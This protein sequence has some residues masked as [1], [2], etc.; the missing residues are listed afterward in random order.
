M[1]SQWERKDPT[2]DIQTLFER[3]NKRFFKDKLNRVRVVWR[4]GMTK[5]SG[6]FTMDKVK[7]K[8]KLIPTIKLSKELLIFESRKY[9]IEI[10]L[11]SRKMYYYIF[12][13]FISYIIKIN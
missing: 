7:G 8:R 3:F 11:V 6:T 13:R 2:P 12:N 5:S 9:I 10:L 4:T 1:H